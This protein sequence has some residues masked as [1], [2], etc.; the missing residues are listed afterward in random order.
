MELPED[1]RLAIAHDANR[2]TIMEVV[3][4]LQSD[5]VAI[6]RDVLAAIV[7]TLEITEGVWSERTIRR[8]RKM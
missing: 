2:D 6:T 5:K 4:R 1:I 8:A 7:A 3:T